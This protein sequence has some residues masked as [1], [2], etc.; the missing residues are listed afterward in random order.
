MDT[1]GILLLLGS[2]FFNAGANTLMKAAF[3]HQSD[4][5]AYGPIAA[6]V[7]I[8][9]NPYAIG[10]IA[11]FGISFVFLSAA[12]SRV[13]LSIAYPFM[14]GVV[15]LLVLSVSVLVFHEPVSFW[16]VAGIGT[17]LAGILILSFKG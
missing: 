4:L 1:L 9:T 7:R 2:A 16:R 17:I 13:D 11:C 3:G 12:L 14:A 10:G 6:C 5:L 15:F 8:M